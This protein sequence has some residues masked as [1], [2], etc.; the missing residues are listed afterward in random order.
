MVDSPHNNLATAEQQRPYTDRSAAWL[1]ALVR[2][3]GPELT[4]EQ[5]RPGAPPADNVRGRSTPRSAGM[6]RSRPAT[7]GQARSGGMTCRAGFGEAAE[8]A[9]LRKLMFQSAASRAIRDDRTTTS[10]V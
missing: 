4:A 7:A 8:G 5:S 1:A 6:I 9:G 3:A 2:G 10:A